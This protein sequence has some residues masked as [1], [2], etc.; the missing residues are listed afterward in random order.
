M[1]V[2]QII[3]LKAQNN[4]NDKNT[5]LVNVSAGFSFAGHMIQTNYLS[6]LAV[7]PAQW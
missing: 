6:F 1:R 3:E 2:V 4:N 7:H 5:S